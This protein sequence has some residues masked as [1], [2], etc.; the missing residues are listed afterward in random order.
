MTDIIATAAASSLIGLVIGYFF[1]RWNRDYVTRSQCAD[2]KKDHAAEDA[3]FTDFKK[4]MRESMGVIKGL[5]LVVAS[6]GKVSME[7]LKEL[8][9]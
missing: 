6:G 9:R 1:K 5:L 8:M 7:D 2:C 4:E 3:K